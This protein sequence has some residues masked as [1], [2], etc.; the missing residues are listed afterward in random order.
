MARE[1]KTRYPDN[2]PKSV[3]GVQKPGFHAIPASALL[4]LGAAMADGKRKY[5]LT[6]W[7]SNSVAASVYFDAKLRH[8]FAWWDARQELAHDSLVHHLG[9]DMA[10]SAIILDAIATGNLVDDRPDVPGAFA[11]MVLDWTSKT[12]DTKK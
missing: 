8:I 7:R 10:C 6:N 2:N 1:P 3:I 11:Q 4:H 12:T 9:H 5:G